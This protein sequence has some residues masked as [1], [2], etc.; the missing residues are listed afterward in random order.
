M[1][2][3]QRDYFITTRVFFY[4]LNIFSLELSDQ[5]LFSK[6]TVTLALLLGYYGKY[7]EMIV[8]RLLGNYVHEQY[9]N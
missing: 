7:C 5:S 2:Y 8:L 4:Y 1:L 6:S 3:F 9:L